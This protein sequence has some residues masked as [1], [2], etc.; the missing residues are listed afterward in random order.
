VIGDSGEGGR[1]I[2]W[3]IGALAAVV[4]IA[5]GLIGRR[6]RQ[7]P[8]AAKWWVLFVAWATLTTGWAVEPLLAYGRL[9]TMAALIL[10]YL[11]VTCLQLTKKELS[12]TLNMA[13][14]GGCLASVYAAYQFS[15]HHLFAHARDPRAT[16]LLGQRQEDPNF[17]AS[18]LLVPVAL[19][20]AAF[21]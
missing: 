6:F 3:F 12:W 8:R 9:P 21:L 18:T 10:L 2:T 16:I 20:L 14:L 5:C 11:A 15:L 1:T 7:P 19:A 13:I 17:F 4:L